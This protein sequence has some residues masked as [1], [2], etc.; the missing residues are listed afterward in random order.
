MLQGRFEHRDHLGNVGAISDGGVQWMTAGRGVI[1]S[2][3]PLQTDGK[4]RGFQLWLNLP[5]K[6]KMMP[7]NYENI[8]ADGLAH[9]D[10]GSLELTLVAGSGEINGHPVEAKKE[11]PDTEPRY[12][13]IRN[14]GD[15]SV[16]VNVPL[17]DGYT[18]LVYVV[19]GSTD[20]ARASQLARYS[21]EGE[22]EFELNPQSRV[23]LLA[24]KPI[25]EPVVQ[26]GPFVMNSYEEIEQA[27]RDYQG[28]V[29]TE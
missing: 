25:R 12:W 9:Y 21:N 13:D 24:G 26:Y 10:L 5:A 4:V 6:D 16:T 28:G 8:E 29:L 27:V 1:H 22:L 17:P 14:P 11:V 23:L 15:E 20:Q 7:A 18:S 3:M 19:D 2:E